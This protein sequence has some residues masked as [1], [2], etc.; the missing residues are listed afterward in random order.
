MLGH[1]HIPMVDRA[2]GATILNPGS[3]VGV[4]GVQTSYTFA[5]VELAS[6]EVRF[7]EVRTGREVRRDPI[8]LD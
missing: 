2:P 7:Y 4:P 1:T 6:L 8:F 5:I 3:L